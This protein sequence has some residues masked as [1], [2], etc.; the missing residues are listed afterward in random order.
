MHFSAILFDLD[1][2]LIETIPLY[3]RAYAAAFGVHN[4]V[5]SQEQFLH[6]YHAGVPIED[7]LAKFAK[8]GTDTSQVRAHRDREYMDLLRREAA[9]FPGALELLRATE[10]VPRAIV[11]GSLQTYIDA[12]D[13]KLDVNDHFDT[14]ITADLMKPFHKPHPHGFLLAADA[15][16]VAPEDCLVIGDQLFD[17]EAATAAGMTSCLIWREYTPKHA[18]G[19]ADMDVRSLAEI[20]PLIV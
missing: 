4:V 11:T 14:V 5:L 20:L 16:G 17:V 9:Y 10:S 3:A 2:T 19:A 6:L 7:T 8:P 12:I 15:L 13:E 18:A 1:G